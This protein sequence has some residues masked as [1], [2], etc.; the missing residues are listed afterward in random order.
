MS[1]F[2]GLIHG[3]YDAKKDNLPGGATLHSM[4]T[5]HGP[6]GDTFDKASTVELKPAKMEGTMVSFVINSSKMSLVMG[7][8]SPFPGVH[9]REFVQ[10]GHHRLGPARVRQTF[11]H[12]PPVLADHQEKV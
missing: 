2:M 8:L 12:L 11:F 9:V 7:V 3:A 1:E 4:M 6:D 5:P 10:H